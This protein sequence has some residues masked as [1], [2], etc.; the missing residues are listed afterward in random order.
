MIL[1]SPD[2][3]IRVVLSLITEPFAKEHCTNLSLDD[4][5]DFRAHALLEA[6]RNLEAAGLPCNLEDVV[7]AIRVR[8][9]QLGTHR[10]DHVNWFW[11]GQQ[12]CVASPYRGS[13]LL[14]GYDLDYLKTL[15]ARRKQVT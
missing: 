10:A 3:E 14:L 5:T 12:L 1:A 9:R 4:V 13:V 11:L 8:D 15:S 2:H 7:A 6:Y